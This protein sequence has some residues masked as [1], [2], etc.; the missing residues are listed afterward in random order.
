LLL[1]AALAIPAV[2]QDIDGRVLEDNSGEPLV[3]AELRFHKGGL[4][5]L[6]ADLETDRDGRFRA[7][8]IPAGEY[9]V[10]VSKPN[11]VTATKLQVPSTGLPVCRR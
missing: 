8:G 3:N 5:E 9:T 6:A 11:H 2:A 4:R 1:F 7:S 10:D